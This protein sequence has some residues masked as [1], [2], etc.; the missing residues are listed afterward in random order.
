MGRL[1]R[2]IAD[3]KGDQF[4]RL[5]VRS[6][7]K[8]CEWRGAWSEQVAI[9]ARGRPHRARDGRPQERVVAKLPGQ[10]L[11][12]LDFEPGV[13]VALEFHTQR[14]VQALAERDAVL[15]EAVGQA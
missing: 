8:G 1:L 4:L 5:E 12:G 3:L 13:A 15:D 10:P 2:A 14:Q 9:Q 11:V 7:G 6:A